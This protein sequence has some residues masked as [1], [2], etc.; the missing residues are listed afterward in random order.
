M[1]KSGTIKLEQNIN[2]VMTKC[3]VC[4]K[5]PNCHHSAVNQKETMRTDGKVTENTT[6]NT[7]NI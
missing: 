6:D 2:L 4:E 5:S 3:Q 7:M 1:L